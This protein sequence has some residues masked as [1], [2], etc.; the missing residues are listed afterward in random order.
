MKTG[1]FR[2]AGGVALLA[3]GAPFSTRAQFVANYPVI[4]VPPPPAQYYAL[5]K[6]ASKPAP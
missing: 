2:V 5:S 1:T 6:P 3:L 4:I